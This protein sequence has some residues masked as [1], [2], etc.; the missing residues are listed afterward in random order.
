MYVSIML[1]SSHY[2]TVL[3]IQIINMIFHVLLFVG[4]E[5]RAI[6]VC[7]SEPVDR[8]GKTANPTKSICDKF[9]FNTV[10]TRAQSLVVAVGNPY[11]LFKIEDQCPNGR[12]CWREYV[13]HCIEC[14]TLRCTHPIPFRRELE[15]LQSVIFKEIDKSLVMEEPAIGS[16]D[17]ILEAYNRAVRYKS[18]GRGEIAYRAKL[19]LRTIDGD[20]G[21]CV[22]TGEDVTTVPEIIKNTPRGQIVQCFLQQINHR[23]CIA[24]PLDTTHK[25]IHILG[26]DNRRGAFGDSIVDVEITGDSSSKEHFFG[27]VVNVVEQGEDRQFIC[28]VD[29]YNSIIF[30]PVDRKSPKIVNLPPISRGLVELESGV[31]PKS[32]KEQKIKVHEVVCFEPTSVK[33]GDV[34][35]VRESIPMKIA[36]NLLFIV[37]P[38]KWNKERRFPLGVVV[39]VLPRGDSMFHAERLLRVQY[40]VEELKAIDEKIDQNSS[41]AP[42]SFD[43]DGAITIDPDD[44]RNLDDALTLKRVRVEDNGDHVFEFGVHIAN[45]ARYLTPGHPLDKLMMKRVTSVYGSYQSKNCYQPMLPHEF[46][47]D[48]S[49]N[50]SASRY[51]M[52]VVGHAVLRHGSSS[53][54]IVNAEDIEIKEGIVRSCLR[55]TYHDAENIMSQMD[56]CVSDALGKRLEEYRQLCQRSMPV[57]EQLLHLANIATALRIVRLGEQGEVYFP[58]D[59]ET[60]M[61][62]V[63]HSLVEE[64]MIWANSKVANKLIHSNLPDVVLR[65]QP[66][67][68]R[69]EKMAFLEEFSSIIHSNFQ[70]SIIYIYICV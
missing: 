42:D 11:R 33:E 54:E 1:V 34:P 59:A 24:K 21:W 26:V 17:A 39:G 44:A 8:E 3:S 31:E 47:S 5:Y 4:R 2:Y 29:Q 41:V 50:E 22:W 23:F 37:W 61:C 51:S 68:N 13:R 20:Q 70:V 46:T 28:R 58:T 43:W 38:L 52:S 48:I 53:M 32:G 66:S 65:I 40:Q 63:A 64:M 25:E 12:G 57:K 36:L 15:Y 30:F 49:L 35:R 16:E 56:N 19:A 45:V 10:I 18:T 67:P 55:L 7:T 9:V 14:Q 6:F 69:V 27:K 60:A 62:P